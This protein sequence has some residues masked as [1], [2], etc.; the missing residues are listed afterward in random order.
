MLKRLIQRWAHRRSFKA[1]VREANFKRSIDFKKYL[2]I[3]LNGEYCAFSKQRLKTLHKQ[4][5][6]KKGIPFRKIEKMVV[7][8][9]K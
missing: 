2:V 1:A 3:F 6:F 9:T 8:S 4:G 7:Y 5:C